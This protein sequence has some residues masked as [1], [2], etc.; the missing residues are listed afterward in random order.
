[1]N[2]LSRCILI[3]TFLANT[4]SF[5]LNAFGQQ[6]DLYSSVRTSAVFSDG[7][8]VLP[9]STTIPLETSRLTSADALVQTLLK[10]DFVAASLGNRAAATTK[11]L[12]SW[13]FPVLVTISDNEQDLLITIGLR[14]VT[15]PQKLPAARLLQ[16]LEGNQKLE[17]ASFVFNRTQ[18]R[19]E[20]LSQVRN[21]GEP[22]I[23]LR[24]EI[25]RL[26]ILA[27]DSENLWNLD[28]QFGGRPVQ[29]AD[30]TGLEASKSSQTAVT[31]WIESS[32][33]APNAEL[34]VAALLGRWSAGRT[35]TEAFA[36]QLNA[37]STFVLVSVV[38][39]KQSRSSGTFS[40]QGHRLSLEGSD[41]SKIVATLTLISAGEFQFLQQAA[42]ASGTPLNFRKAK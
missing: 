10:A 33:A 24:D 37:D 22:H 41:G 38:S 14:A 32:S 27:R 18:G 12:D 15:N 11:Q 29:A 40:V 39:G 6:D 8:N 16:L 13:K 21:I 7:T 5:A 35:T 2:K 23:L 28:N 4:A 34:S 3:V 30:S 9:G 42:G 26:A 36:L 1:M 17:R 20:L 19:L 31:P 25:K